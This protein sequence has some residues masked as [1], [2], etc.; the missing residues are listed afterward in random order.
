MTRRQHAV[1]RAREAWVALDRYRF[2]SLSVGIVVCGLLLCAPCVGDDLTVVDQS[3]DSDMFEFD[4]VWRSRGYGW[5]VVVKRKKVQLYHVAGDT[6]IRDKGQ[7]LFSFDDFTP[8][9]VSGTNRR[10]IRTRVDD[11]DYL[12][13]FERVAALPQACVDPAKSDVISVF[14]AVVDYFD[15]HYPFFDQRHIDWPTVVAQHRARISETMSDKKLFDVIKSLLTRTGDGHVSIEGRVNGRKKSFEVPDI[16]VRDRAGGGNWG[17]S[18]FGVPLSLGWSD[19]ERWRHGVGARLSQD[20][21]RYR[22]GG[23]ISY[24]LLERDVGYLV[25][26]SMEGMK[27]RNVE[28]I[29]RDVVDV[30]ANARSVVVDVS[31]NEGG[32]DSVSRQIAGYFASQRTLGYFKFAGDDRQAK[33]QAL[34]IEPEKTRLSSDVPVFVITSQETY[35]AAE[36]FVLSMRALPNVT[37]VGESTAGILS[38]TLWKPLPNGWIISLSNEVY[39]DREMRSFEAVGISPMISFDVRTQGKISSGDVASARSLIQSL[40]A[41][42]S[43]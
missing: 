43:R 23:K 15:A 32:D 17:P 9:V 30:F 42:A 18:L 40:H 16:V 12:H 27:R 5:V 20:G 33:P 2:V 3:G 38:D 29:M 10:V 24:G 21:L 7:E 36:V 14:N 22:A 28:K 34:Y 39:L 4:G 31:V 1:R 25:I 6:C 13:T 8:G 26:K 11:S 19:P 37:H 41:R 35:S